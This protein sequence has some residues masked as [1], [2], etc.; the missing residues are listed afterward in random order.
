MSQLKIHQ[1]FVNHEIFFNST[2]D[3]LFNDHSLQEQ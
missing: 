1:E 2:A 3:L